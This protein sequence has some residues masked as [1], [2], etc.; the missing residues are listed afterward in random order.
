MPISKRPR[1]KIKHQSRNHQSHVEFSVI[2]DENG[3]ARVDISP[4][5]RI[6]SPQ[7]VAGTYSLK[8]GY[9][10]ESGK[11]KIAFSHV[12]EVH[13]AFLSERDQLISAFSR[14]ICLDTNTDQIGDVRVS[15]TALALSQNPL[16][17]SSGDVHFEIKA[18]V[19]FDV[20]IDINPE[21]VGLDIALRYF[22]NRENYSEGISGIIMDSDLGKHDQI[23][24]R[25][26]PYL[27]NRLIP[28]NSKLLYASSDTGDGFSNQVMRLCDSWAKRI[29]EKLR[30]HPE[31]LKPID[32]SYPYCRGWMVVK[33]D[34]E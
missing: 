14:L 6:S 20:P 13:G 3:Q 25:E 28:N 11:R 18:Y 5:G 9:D 15:V 7:G 34:D 33:S 8:R 12:G 27:G 32:D 19:L 2:P 24:R 22:A 30:L 1:K 31:D 17:K 26:I 21:M 10:R 29:M 16:P 23:N 4:D